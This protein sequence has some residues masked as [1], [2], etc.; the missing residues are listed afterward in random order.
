MATLIIYD[1]TG[2]IYYQA[3][4]AVTEPTGIPFLWVDVPEGKYIKS[5][6]IS[7]ATPTA[8]LEDIPKSDIDIKIQEIY[9]AL[10]ELAEGAV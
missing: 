7:G 4:G 2:T 1:S 8:V 6:D 10:A 3:S 5:V 9:V